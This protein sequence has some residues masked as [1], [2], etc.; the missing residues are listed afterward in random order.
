MTDIKIN[1]SDVASLIGKHRFK[2]QEESIEYVIIDNNLCKTVVDEDATIAME[3]VEESSSFIDACIGT[4][5]ETEFKEAVS[6]YS[7][8]IKEVAWNRGISQESPIIAMALQQLNLEVGT[9]D[10]KKCIDTYE[11]TAGVSVTARNTKCYIYKI[12]DISCNAILAG[13]TDGLTT[14]KNERAVLENKKRMKSTRYPVPEYDIIQLRCYMKLTN[15]KFG[16]LNEAYPDGTTRQ[17]H[18]EWDDV[19]WTQIVNPLKTVITN[20]WN[21]VNQ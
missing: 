1:C 18:I 7:T 2:S 14:Y 5:T 16:I 12:P 4:K 6:A 17:T 13:R 9:R 11:E 8:K 21:N 15:S 10:E 20:I 3:L 19:Q